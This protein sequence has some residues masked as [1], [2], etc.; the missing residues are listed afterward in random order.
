MTERSVFLEALD[1]RDPAERAAYLD[2]ACAGVPTFRQRIEQLLRAHEEL[3]TFLEVPAVEQMVAAERSLTFLGPPREQGSL[4]RL[5]DYEVLEGLGRG[6]AGVVFKA[7]DTKLQRIV[8]LKALAPRLAAN[9]TARQRFI[10]EA[11][12]AAAVRDDHVVAIHAVSDEGPVPYLVMEYVCGMT[13]EERL[14]QGKPLEL[15]EVLRIGSQIA[16]GLAAAHAQG[17]AHRDLKPGN[18]LLENSVQ[19]VK[20]TDFGL[21]Q[22]ADCPG[23]ATDRVVAGTPLYMSP[24]QA[25]GEATDTR[26][27]LFSL[28]S[29]LYT[30]CARRS[31][32][33][34][35]TMVEIL[36]RV[37]DDE[38]APLREIQPGIPEWLCQLIAKLHAKKPCDRFGSAR[39]VRDLLSAQLALLQQQALPAPASRYESQTIQP[40]P[41]LAAAATWRSKPMSSIQAEP[42]PLEFNPKTTALVVI[43]MQ[44]DFVLPGGFGEMLG[45]DTSLLL[46]AV[47][48]LERVLAK[49][50]EK[51]M[52]IV[53]TREGHRGTNG[54]PA[55]H[56]GG[57]L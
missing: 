53:H 54:H 47:E 22:I 42:F 38:P 15:K 2:V 56:S 14:T 37:S 6:A 40:S 13:L 55:P 41:R 24:E 50:R 57:N 9:S 34:A 45:N 19:R 8:A 27:D 12:A 16:A 23:P 7:R 51:K 17:L 30:L 44:R 10:Q 36:K 11:Q 5:D 4:G 35:D 20:I 46:A 3:E 33:R 49:A 28:G 26:T 1:K 18:I 25:R 29:L 48:P 39:E 43:D 32:F 31:P 21:A 52:F